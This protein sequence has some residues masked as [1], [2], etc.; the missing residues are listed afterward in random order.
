MKKLNVVLMIMLVLCVGVGQAGISVH[1]STT[2]Y[3][4]VGGDWMTMG[5]NDI[6]GDGGLGTDGFLFFGDYDGV[7]ETG[8]AW[9]HDTRALPA[10]VTDVAAGANFNSIAD[11]ITG[12]GQI[13]DPVLLDGTDSHGGIAVAT[14]GVAGDTCEVA[15]FTVSGLSGVVRVGVLSGVEGNANGR[16]DPTSITLSDGTSS[17]TVGDHTTSQLPANPGGV[18]AGWV[19]FDIDADGTYAVTGTKRL[20]TQGVSIGG[21]TFDAGGIKGAHTPAPE[22]NATDVPYDTVLTWE[23]G[24]FAGSHTVYFGDSFEDVN[25]ATEAS[26]VYQGEQPLEDTSFDPGRL[27]FGESYYWRVDEVNA[28]PDNTI[29]RG[30]VW[31][32][33]V[34]TFAYPIPGTSTTV[35]ASSSNSAGEG[36]ENT[37][38]WLWS[39]C[40]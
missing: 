11:D 5:T 14:G 24:E 25:T 9:G 29:Y 1:G 20:N 3:Q 26:D 13:D 39:G 12:Y 4:E 2:D 22:N 40:R 7:K 27:A 33:T 36:P 37:I 17:A 18:N 34:E 6:D 32:F 31:Q 38:N 19:F 10:Y 30:D 15:T 8:N 16:W 35:T 28:P 23:P 21:L